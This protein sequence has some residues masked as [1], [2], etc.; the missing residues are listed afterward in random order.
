MDE[1]P[2]ISLIV[3]GRAEY[4]LIIRTA[5]GG[6]ALLKDLGVD[7]LDDL[8]MAADEACD[9]LLHQGRSAETLRLD[10]VDAGDRLMVRLSAEFA[11]ENGEG[12]AALE[13]SRAILETLMPE[14]AFSTLPCGCV[15]QIELTMPKAAV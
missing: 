1:K 8:R 12:G 11:E 15:D 10:V 13:I 3:P 5:L 4:A 2:E 14:V 7:A 6:V 9:C